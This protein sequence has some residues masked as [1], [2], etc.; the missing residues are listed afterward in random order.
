MPGNCSWQSTYSASSKPLLGSGSLT[1]HCRSF[2]HQCQTA[3]WFSDPEFTNVVAVRSSIGAA[4]TSKY[5]TWPPSI[6][7]EAIDVFLNG[8]ASLNCEAAL[9]MGGHLVRTLLASLCVVLFRL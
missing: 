4:S 1:L 6:E 8:L 5:T 3:G 7:V 2:S 9:I